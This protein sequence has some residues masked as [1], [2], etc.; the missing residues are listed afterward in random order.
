M[1]IITKIE[2]NYFRSTYSVDLKDVSDLNIFIGANDSGKSNILKSLNLFF[3]N[4]TEHEQ[5]FSFLDDLTR[6]RE[7]EARSA[8]GRATIWI[9]VYFNNFLNWKSLPNEFVIKKTWNR[10]SDQPEI[11]YPKDV[12]T[13]ILAKFLNKLSFHYVPAV[14]G[15]DIFAHFLSLLHDALLDDEKAGL[16]NSTEELIKVINENTEEMSD[17]I[18][19]GVG[20]ESNIQPPTDL[21]I[22]FNA[23]DFSTGY[24]G[25]SIPLQ[26][27]GDGI[28][29]RHIPFILDFVAKHSKK[30]HI[31]AYEEPE[32]SLEMGPAFELAGQFDSEFCIENQVFLTTHSPAFYDLSGTHVSKWFVH[33]ELVNGEQETKAELVSSQDLLDSKLGV[34]ALVAARAK[35]AYQQIKDLS[36]TVD[37]LDMEVKAGNIPHVIVEGPT[38]KMIMEEAFNRLYPEREKICE[39]IHA[40]GATNI[41]PYLKSAKVLSKEVSH[42]IIGLLDRDSEGRKQMKEFKDNKCVG[43]T[44]FVVISHSRHLY[45]G[46]LPLPAVLQDIEADLKAREG[47]HLNLPIPIEFMFSADLINRALEEGTIEL[48]DRIVKANDPELPTT[49]NLTEIYASNLPGNYLYLSRKVKKDTKMKFAKWVL[50]QEDEEFEC[51]R[52]IFEQIEIVLSID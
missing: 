33:Q 11:A 49:I 47:D 45:A 25:H 15:R 34:A 30:H 4:K 42:P 13:I 12:S 9:K 16:V 20:I 38:D 29:S 24:S 50:Q 51:F 28:Q 43:D 31:W 17:R 3:N 26:K 14:R 32:T 44:D 52:P 10:Y 6:K 37:R 1:K 19:N 5:V 22:L 8:K 23:L 40:G 46:I 41:P 18:L 7:Q 2:I 21:K 39:F 27:R 36:A 48:D 35:E